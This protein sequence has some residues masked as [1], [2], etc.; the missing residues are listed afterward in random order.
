MTRA[1]GLSLREV[2]ETWMWA[3]IKAAQNAKPAVDVDDQLAAW[4][5]AYQG[6]RDRHKVKAGNA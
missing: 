1:L 3:K 6:E 4:A 5:A 2:N